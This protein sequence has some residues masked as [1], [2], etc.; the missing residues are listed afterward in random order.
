M[1]RVFLII[2]LHL[3]LFFIVFAYQAQGN[4]VDWE[5]SE[6]K[7][8]SY[9]LVSGE[10][11]STDKFSFILS[12]E[13]Q[14][15]KVSSMFSFFTWQDPG[16]FDQLIGRKVPIKLNN[17]ETTAEVLTTF[18]YKEGLKVVF[19]FGT[20]PLKEY[21]YTMY[22]FYKD[23][24]IYRIQIVDGLN[25]VASKYFDIKENNWKLDKLITSMNEAF[26]ICKNIGNKNI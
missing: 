5:V 20:F 3:S 19:Y 16:D 14:C 9:A 1:K 23:E 2:L 11:Q 24:G 6:Y 8:Q 15:S 13:D 22:N 12:P 25:F 4:E 21:I 17:I 18:P 7:N 10:I 26:E